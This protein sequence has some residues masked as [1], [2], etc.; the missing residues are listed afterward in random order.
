MENVPHSRATDKKL[1][2]ERVSQVYK[3]FWTTC[4]D[5]YVFGI[6]DKKEINISQLIE[7]PS[8]F[9]IRSKQ[10]NIVEDMVNYLLNI[11][12]KSTKQTLY[13]MPVGLSVKPTEWEEIKDGDFYIING[14]HS[15]EA[16]TFIFDDANNVDKDERENFR[17]WNCFIVWSEDAEKL[18]CISAYYNRTNHFVAV[19]PSWATNILGVRSVWEAM[20][21]CENPMA[22]KFVGIT[23]STRRTVENRR[24]KE[25]FQVCSLERSVLKCI[26][27][28]ILICFQC[29]LI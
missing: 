6:G 9:N 16:S 27:G 19:Q 20:G 29:L 13:I 12:N 28:S 18:R 15:V 7:A 8:T 14:Q 25:T 24:K 4:E 3:K 5:A 26:I 17:Q 22:T 11:P 10:A 21:R 2:Y 23:S 1:D